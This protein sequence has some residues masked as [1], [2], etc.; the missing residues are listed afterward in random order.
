[1][2]N[3]KNYASHVFAAY[4]RPSFSLNDVCRISFSIS[5][6]LFSE[7][8]Y[9][10]HNALVFSP[11]SPRIPYHVPAP[12]VDNPCVRTVLF[13]DD[14][15]T[16]EPKSD[17]AVSRHG[18]RFSIFTM[19]TKRPCRVS[20]WDTVNYKSYRLKVRKQLPKY[21]RCSVKCF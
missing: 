6:R 18:G 14:S 7:K 11:R 16:F 8:L 20:R 2:G 17:L 19:R 13:A 10:P 12:L 4:N 9:F 5:V 15:D 3:T 21:N 1:M